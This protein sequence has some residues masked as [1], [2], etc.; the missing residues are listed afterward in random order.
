MRRRIGLL[1]V[2]GLLAAGLGCKHVAGKCDPGGHPADAYPPPITNPYPHAPAPGVTTPAAPA[3]A[4]KDV[5]AK[6][7]GN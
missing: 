6:L 1:S 3:P 4:A 7:P 5:P 2:A